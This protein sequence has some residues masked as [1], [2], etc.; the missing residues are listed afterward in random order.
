MSIRM[1]AFEI[2][3]SRFV[4]FI[5]CENHADIDTASGL[6]T[7][8]CSIDVGT[9]R[10]RLLA[11]NGGRAL[12]NRSHEANRE[13]TIWQTKI[14]RDGA[15]IIENTGVAMTEL[16]APEIT[17]VVERISVLDFPASFDEREGE[18]TRSGL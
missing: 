7:V 9:K 8:T 18:N 14:N 2:I 11:R 13:T 15:R 6:K 3:I 17:R 10:H 16:E 12:R 4:L 5:Q 1:Y